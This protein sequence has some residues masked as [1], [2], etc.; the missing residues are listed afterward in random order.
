MKCE[1]PDNRDLESKIEIK[2]QIINSIMSHKKLKGVIS[3]EHGTWMILYQKQNN[4][5]KTERSW[6]WAYSLEL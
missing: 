5:Q 4:T 2:E 1:H 3:G 6:A